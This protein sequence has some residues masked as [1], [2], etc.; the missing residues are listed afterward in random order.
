MLEMLNNGHF[1]HAERNLKL[2]KS[3]SE[4]ELQLAC[5]ST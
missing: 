4:K 1:S 5:T 3:D 2:L